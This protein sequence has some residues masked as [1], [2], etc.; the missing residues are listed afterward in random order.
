MSAIHTKVLGNTSV[1]GNANISSVPYKANV[2][3]VTGVPEATASI[4]LG[5]RVIAARH[6]QGNEDNVASLHANSAGE[7]RIRATGSSRK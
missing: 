1:L 3:R 7:Y 6:D 5:R 2:G 4:C